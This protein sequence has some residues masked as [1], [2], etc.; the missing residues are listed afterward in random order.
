MKCNDVIRMLL[1]PI[2]LRAARWLRPLLRYA[3]EGWETRL[4]ADQRGWNAARVIDE[5]KAKWELFL[6]NLEGAGPLGFSHESSDLSETRNVS[7]HNIHLIY[8]YVLALAAHRKDLVSVLDWGGGLGHYHRLGRALL[9]GVA[10][11]YHV[12]E[13]PALAAEGRRLNP[14]V[15]WHEDDGCLDRTY[16]LVMVNGS[17]QYI[18]DWR[19]TVGRIARATG[20]Y[21]FLHRLP[22]VEQGPSYVAVQKA[23]G[24]EM[25]HQQLNQQ[26][27]LKTIEDAGLRLV[28]EFIVGDRPVIPWA[29]AP[30]EMKSWFFIAGG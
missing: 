25:L 24:T 12:K 2:A 21:F 1:P 22:V 5:E 4:S 14:E 13:V 26:E 9:P 3:P 23:Y 16:D 30:C 10:L 29:P 11:D 17:L 18:R 27:V 7:F 20:G 19:E 28:R 6:K 15:R 8:A